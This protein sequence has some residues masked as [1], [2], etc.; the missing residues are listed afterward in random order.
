MKLPIGQGM[1]PAFWMMPFDEGE[2]YL[3][4]GEIDIMETVNAE[5]Q[6]YATFHHNNRTDCADNYLVSQDKGIAVPTLN[7]DYHNYSVIWEQ[8]WIVFMVDN[9]VYNIINSTSPHLPI[10]SVP[11]YIILNTAV[12]G[13]WPESPDETTTW[14]Q[15]NYIDFVRVYQKK[16]SPSTTSSTTNTP[17]TSSSTTKNPTTSTSTTGNNPTTTSTTSAGTTNKPTTTTTTASPTTTTTTT[18][19]ASPTTTTTTTSAPTSTI[20]TTTTSTT[21]GH[22]S[23]AIQSSSASPLVVLLLATA[24]LAI[25]I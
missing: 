20:S 18:T 3:N 13:D 22:P 2:C 14:P 21:T 4:A 25:L 17:T 12:G 8:N 23:S 24:T 9:V 16:S 6:S 1:W 19:T 7:S 10:P 11:F 5:M 15:Y